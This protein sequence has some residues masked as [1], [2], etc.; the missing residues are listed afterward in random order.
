MV[1]WIVTSGEAIQFE[2]I[3]LRAFPGRLKINAFIKKKKHKDPRRIKTTHFSDLTITTASMTE[4]L[5]ENNTTNLVSLNRWLGSRLLLFSLHNE[6]M[7]QQVWAARSA[8]VDKPPKESVAAQRTP[9]RPSQTI[10]LNA[11]ERKKKRPNT[12][13]HGFWHSTTLLVSSLSAPAREK[14]KSGKQLPAYKTSKRGNPRVLSL[15]TICS[16]TA[17][18][19]N[20]Q[21]KEG[22]LS[23]KRE[24]AG[25][26]PP[27]R[28][29]LH[30]NQIDTF[31]S[32]LARACVKD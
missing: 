25:W 18:R 5:R 28:S 1:K 24:M 29:L 10:Y 11:K 2:T 22:E 8:W 30:E 17:T 23:L 26:Q 31:N 12:G 7:K 19:A 20:P 3:G 14:K 15:S 21:L 9:T 27:L 32:Q 6:V 13:S 16:N 4:M